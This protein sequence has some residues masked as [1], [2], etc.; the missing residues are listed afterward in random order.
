MH[1]VTPAAH[2][3][4][5]F[6]ELAADYEAAGELRYASALQ[7][8]DAYVRRLEAGRRGDGL[9]HGWIPEATF[10]LA[11]KGALLGCARLRLGLSPQLEYEGG[12][13]GYDVRPSMR[14]R[15]HGTTLLRLVLIEARALA[16][17]RV[18]ITCDDDNFGSIRVIERNGGVLADMGVSEASGKPLR[19]YWI[20]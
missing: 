6:L 10:W 3:R 14:R 1:L 8:F 19:Q 13:I 20:G 12:H 7:D 9:P 5:A 4:A 17:E 16:I 2:R 18:R 11:S 15:G